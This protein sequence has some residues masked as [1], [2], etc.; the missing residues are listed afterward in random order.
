MAT[1]PEITS[2]LVSRRSALR[3]GAAGTAL[4]IAGLVMPIAQ[5]G[6]EASDSASAQ[7]ARIYQLEADFHRAQTTQ[8]IDL[9]MSLWDPDGTLVFEGNPQSPFDGYDQI[10]AFW[11]SSGTFTHRLISLVPSFKIQIKV[12]GNE[13]YLYFECHTIG[14]Y[15]LPT[16]FFAGD[17]F[18]AGTIHKARDRWVFWQMTAGTGAI[19]SPDHY[20]FP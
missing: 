1:N 3:L 6:A 15:D 4:G 16:R 14:D 11:L 9:M 13:A 19:L 5:A 17:L 8:D 18:L 12:H 10:K 2:R 20:Y 7:V